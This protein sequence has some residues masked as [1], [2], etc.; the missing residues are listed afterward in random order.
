MKTGIAILLAGLLATAPMAA[1]AEPPVAPA[2]AQTTGT[3]TGGESSGAVFDLDLLPL[4]AG[5]LAI[6]LVAVVAAG[7]SDG[8]NTST[9]TN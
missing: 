8:N 7:T 3:A 4:W 6:G 2:P 1:L 9:T 5:L